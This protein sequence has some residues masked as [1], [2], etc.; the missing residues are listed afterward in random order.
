MYI[1]AEG[2]NPRFC[3]RR[4]FLTAA[5]ASAAGYT[6][7]EKLRLYVCVLLESLKF[8]IAGAKCAKDSNARPIF[9]IDLLETY[10]W[11]Y[12]LTSSTDNNTLHLLEKYFK[13]TFTFS[14]NLH[15]FEKYERAIT[16]S[17]SS[18]SYTRHYTLSLP[19]VRILAENE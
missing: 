7:F 16:R 14:R 6:V 15:I 19:G 18:T 4:Q 17:V 12:Q 1:Y 2:R 8:T 13:G 10:K 5:A 11:L 3:T 9:L